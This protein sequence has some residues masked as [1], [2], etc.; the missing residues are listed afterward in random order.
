MM[1]SV[2]SKHFARSAVQCSWFAVI[3]HWVVWYAT[4]ML[5]FFSHLF[6]RVKPIK[7]RMWD[8]LFCWAA[9][10]SYNHGERLL[11]VRWYNFCDTHPMKT[12]ISIPDPLF[13]A[14]EQFA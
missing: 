5:H 9:S 6:R 2:L 8:T 12:A 3:L 10:P 11:L 4:A 14:A 13:E 7:Y 1:I